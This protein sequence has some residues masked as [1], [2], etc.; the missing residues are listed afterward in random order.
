MEH[1]SFSST[2]WEGCY[3]S[4]GV[5]CKFK[6]NLNPR[7]TEGNIPQSAQSPEFGEYAPKFLAITTKFLILVNITQIHN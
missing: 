2:F 4:Y 6:H 1:Q 3:R 7:I 5:Q